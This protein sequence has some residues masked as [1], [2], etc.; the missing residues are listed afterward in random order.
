LDELGKYPPETVDYIGIL[1]RGA[2]I[3]KGLLEWA[4]PEEYTRIKGQ[5]AALAF[6]YYHL[7][8][9]SSSFIGRNLKFHKYFE[10]INNWEG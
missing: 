1:N 7:I 2:I 5:A 8:Q 6:L 3:R 4:S 10:P 9:S